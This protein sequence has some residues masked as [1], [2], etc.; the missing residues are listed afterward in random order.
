MAVGSSSADVAEDAIDLAGELYP[1]VLELAELLSLATVV[2][3]GLLREA[4]RRFFADASVGLEA[5]FIFS[6]LV[7]PPDAVGVT[8]RT[9][10]GPALRARLS[11][12]QNRLDRAWALLD[13][14]HTWLGGLA[15]VEEE[16]RYLVASRQPGR[17]KRLRELLASACVEIR[18]RPTGALGSWAR[19]MLA[20]LGPDWRS[21][22]EL[23]LL[24]ILA[25][26]ESQSNTRAGTNPDEQLP[27]GP[28]TMLGVRA[29]DGGAEFARWSPALATLGFAE[30]A[31]PDRGKHPPIV[32]ADGRPIVLEA[33]PRLE[34]ISSGRLLT[35]DARQHRLNRRRRSD[36][37]RPLG[38]PGGHAGHK[39]EVNGVAFSPDGTRLATASDDGTARIWDTATGTTIT[40]LTGHT[41]A[42][43]GVTFS[44]DGTRLA[45]ASADGTAR[46]WDT[47]TGTTITTLTGHTNTVLGVRS[48]ERRVGKECA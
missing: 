41:N 5:E 36:D 17:T 45:T 15:R 14:R 26:G 46:I 33:L 3:P 30:L 47:A 12:D 29:I 4:R 13:E 11:R 1:D 21:L 44:P 9:A 31:V 25:N 39:G 20:E 19:R 16:I 27:E 6:V 42:V 40:T 34:A 8:F 24:D 7:N 10:V 43:L 28:R 35:L 38:R 2:E 37:F 32:I 23:R 18:H 48:E 22:D